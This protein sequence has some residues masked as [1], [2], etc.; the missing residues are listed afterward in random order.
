M[1]PPTKKGAIGRM[2][3]EDQAR[4]F[5][6]MKVM[7]REDCGSGF[8]DIFTGTKHV[9]SSIGGIVVSSSYNN[10]VQGCGSDDATRS[11]TV[12][13]SHIITAQLLATAM[14]Q[15]LKSLQAPP[16][17]TPDFR[18]QPGTI[19]KRMQVSMVCV[20]CELRAASVA[21]CRAACGGM[22][23]GAREGLRR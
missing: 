16:W 12:R 23:K 13:L 6:W 4:I 11:S 1:A 8:E 2:K 22:T 7:G 14:Q 9:I 19:R 21:D 17:S 15:T 5:V 10:I 3:G 18:N 20:R